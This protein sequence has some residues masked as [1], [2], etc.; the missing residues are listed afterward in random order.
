[1]SSLQSRIANGSVRALARARAVECVRQR[2]RADF[3][4]HRHESL[5]ELL[6]VEHDRALAE[7][8]DPSLQSLTEDE[9]VEMELRFQA[10]CEEDDA[11][12]ALWQS[13]LAS[14]RDFDDAALRA[15]VDA[16]AVSP[17]VC[18]ICRHG[19]LAVS[20]GVVF[21]DHCALRIDTHGERVDIE[22]VRDLLSRSIVGHAQGCTSA[23]RFAVDE[24]FG[25]QTLCLTCERCEAFELIL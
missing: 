23:P 9:Y 6:R 25:L 1:M 12:P 15:A 22:S 17:C 24:R 8:A 2:R 16:D 19:S 11:D 20:F 5:R 3:A 21:C 18:P 7:L 14:A 13:L 10:A 4:R